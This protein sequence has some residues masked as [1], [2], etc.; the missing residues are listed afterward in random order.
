MSRSQLVAMRRPPASTDVRPYQ[1]SSGT[2]GVMFY[3]E[4][5]AVCVHDQRYTDD[6]P[7]DGCQIYAR[8]LSSAPGS[9]SYP[10]EWVQ[11]LVVIPS[12]SGQR[13]WLP[14]CTAFQDRRGAMASGRA[15]C[16]RTLDMFS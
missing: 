1:P 16:P 12:L 8:A 3:E 13:M 10:K 2:E 9:P 14:E 15:F 5:C 11:R 4:M 6:N 7:E